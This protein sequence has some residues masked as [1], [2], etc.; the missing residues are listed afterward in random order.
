MAAAI[1]FVLVMS[2]SVAQA[3]QPIDITWCGSPTIT[4][5]VV[6]SQEFKINSFEGKDIVMSNHPNKAFHNWS[7]H[8]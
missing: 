6:D 2:I 8:L 7:Y 1:A 4:M 5:A 3:Q